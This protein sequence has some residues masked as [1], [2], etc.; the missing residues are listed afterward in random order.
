MAEKKELVG[1]SLSGKEWE[2]LIVRRYSTPVLHWVAMI[3]GDNVDTLDEIV[4]KFWDGK[5]ACSTIQDWRNI[6]GEL[7]DIISKEYNKVEAAGVV[8]AA[9][10]ML[11]SSLYGDFMNHLGCRMELYALINTSNLL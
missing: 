9:D 6:A 4:K 5:P 3:V 8:V 11:V 1:T 10:K 7:N 2:P